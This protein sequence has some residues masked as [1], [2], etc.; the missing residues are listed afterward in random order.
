MGNPTEVR[1]TLWVAHMLLSSIVLLKCIVLLHMHHIIQ[2]VPTEHS[3]ETFHF[4]NSYGKRNETSQLSIESES[5]NHS[6]PFFEAGEKPQVPF[7]YYQLLRCDNN[8]LEFTIAE[9]DITLIIPEGAVS[10]GATIHFEIGVAMYGPFNFAETRPISPIIWLCIR[11]DS[12]LCKPLQ[13]ILPHFL[14]GLTNENSHQYDVDFA[15]ATHDLSSTEQVSYD[16]RK[17]ETKPYL[18]SSGSRCYGILQTNHCCFYCLKAKLAPKL[19][20]EAD[21]YLVQIISPSSIPKCEIIQFCAVYFLKTC[22]KV[23]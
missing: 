7:L 23:S 20:K 5:L 22:I 9:H 15:K 10:V 16:F 21:Y 6:P 11:E 2:T 1:Y 19:I 18:T 14:P 13:I 12:S 3:K 17:C 8:G 4:K